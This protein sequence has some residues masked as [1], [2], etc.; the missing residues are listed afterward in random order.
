MD[1]SLNDDQ[2]LIRDTFRVFFEQESSLELVREA[3]P[4]GFSEILWGRLAQTGAVEMGVSEGRGGGGAGLLEMALVAEEAGRA[5]APVPL[6]EAMV[7]IRL[8]ERAG[9]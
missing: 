4:L 6:V 3:E 2:Q 7:A 9:A 1:L 8:L 5:L